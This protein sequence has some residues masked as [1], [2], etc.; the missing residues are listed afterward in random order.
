MRYAPF[1][2]LLAALARVQRRLEGD[3]LGLLVWDAYRPVRATL[4]M[5][6]WTRRVGREA[7]VRDGYIAARSRH[8]LG[9]VIDLTPVDAASRAPLAM[10]TEFDT[11]STAAHT[12]SATGPV[13]ANR[14]RLRRAMAAKGWQ[15]Y[16]QEWWHFGFALERPLRFDVPVR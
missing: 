13:M 9:V 12:D 16:A 10:G 4:A 2:T 14:D 5:V 15:S 11:F 6:E 8:N 7:P 3:G 1:V